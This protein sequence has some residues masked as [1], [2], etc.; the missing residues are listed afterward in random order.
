MAV[1]PRKRANGI[2]YWVCTSFRGEKHWERS[3]TDKREAERLDARRK[4]EVKAGTFAPTTDGNRANVKTWATTWLAK[5]TVRAADIERGQIRDH[6]LT[7]E[8]FASLQLRDVRPRHMIR[9]VEE[10]KD[11]PRKRRPGTLSQKSVSNVIGILRTMFRDAVIQELM[12]QNPV[13]ALPRGML[14]RKGQKRE[15]YQLEDVRAL[16]C[17]AGHP[18][19][20][21]FA[22]LAFYCGLREGEGCGRR[23]RDWDRAAKPLGALIVSTQY[24]DK[25]LKTDRP[26]KVPVHPELAAILDW[27]WNVGWEI[28][29]CRKPGPDDWIVPQ[30]GL[31]DVAHT[32]SSGYKLWRRACAHAGV[33]NL[34]LHSTRHTFL[35]LARRNGARKD[36]IEKVTHNA[37]G[38]VVDTYTHFDWAPLCEAVLC[39]PSV[40]PVDATVDAVLGGAVFGSQVA[41]ALGLEPRTR[42]LTAACS[43]N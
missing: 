28:V 8:W 43:T 18:Q 33:T 42:R 34:S 22:A 4:R 16:L 23:W 13:A 30:L 6:V 41:P 20:A 26:R 2:V 19:R 25:S 14:S 31:P 17:K 40:L 7:R 21:V 27:W 36:V 12:D 1:V 3:G 9:L 11:A 39:F 15:P 38:D 35:T 32:K 29:Y 5:R 37:K 10:L 24:V